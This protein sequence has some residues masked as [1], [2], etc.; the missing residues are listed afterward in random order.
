[1]GSV[2]TI[3]PLPKPTADVCRG[4]RR[5]G[6]HWEVLGIGGAA[7]SAAEAGEL[8]PGVRRGAYRYR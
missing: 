2:W 5:R 4:D 6:G 1:M 3:Q 8:A 7:Q